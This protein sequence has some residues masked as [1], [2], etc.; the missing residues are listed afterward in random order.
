MIFLVNRTH[1]T[2]TL[3]PFP[4]RLSYYCENH[5]TPL[6]PV[7]LEDIYALQGKLEVAW[8]KGHCKFIGNH[9][10]GANAF[11]A[12]YCDQR[13]SSLSFDGGFLSAHTGKTACWISSR[14]LNRPLLPRCIIIGRCLILVCLGIDLSVGLSLV[15]QQK[16]C[17]C[18]LMSSAQQTFLA[19]W[20]FRWAVPHGTSIFLFGFLYQGRTDLF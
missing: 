13:S 6:L 19:Y 8:C 20:S 10:I 1:G 17:I 12:K 7:N 14:P 5:T 4:L 9:L 18:H 2:I 16:S 15:A 3:K 11:S